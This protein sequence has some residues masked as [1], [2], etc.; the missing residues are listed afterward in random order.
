MPQKQYTAFSDVEIL[1][2]EKKN[3]FICPDVNPN[4]LFCWGKSVNGTLGR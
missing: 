2:T 1:Y 3:V 4:T